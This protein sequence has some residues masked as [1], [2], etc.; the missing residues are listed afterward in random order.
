LR[1]GG[2]QDARLQSSPWAVSSGTVLLLLEIGAC[3]RVV[4]VLAEELVDIV[5]GQMD[6]LPCPRREA[7]R[8]PSIAYK[9]PH[10]HSTLSARQQL[11]RYAV[12]ALVI[13]YVM[14]SDWLC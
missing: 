10:I 8:G 6:L 2:S 3:C 4:L 7:F 13:G 5:H 1:L 9:Q 14:S 11:S 12:C